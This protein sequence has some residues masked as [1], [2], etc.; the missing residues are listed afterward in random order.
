MLDDDLLRVEATRKRAGGQ[1]SEKPWAV[2]IPFFR[3][4][5]TLRRDR[6]KE[7]ADRLVRRAAPKPAEPPRRQPQRTVD[8]ASGLAVGDKV[9]M[10]YNLGS[11]STLGTIIGFPLSGWGTVLWDALSDRHPGASEALELKRLAKIG[12]PKGDHNGKANRNP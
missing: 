1:D 9:R 7:A 3:S 12:E 4:P 11:E 10:A 2:K 8:A 6:G 5:L